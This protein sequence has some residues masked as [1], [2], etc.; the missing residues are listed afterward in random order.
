MIL[1][2]D[3]F[4]RR[5]DFHSGWVQRYMTINNNERDTDMYFRPGV[6]DSDLDS[7]PW[8]SP[9]AREHREQHGGPGEYV[10]GYPD[11][12]RLDKMDLAALVRLQEHLGK[13][14][15][16]QDGVTEDEYEIVTLMDGTRG[17]Q[18]AEG[19]QKLLERE[20]LY[21]KE[22]QILEVYREGHRFSE[23]SSFGLE[24]TEPPG[25][26]HTLRE[27]HGEEGVRRNL[28]LNGMLRM[29]RE[30]DSDEALVGYY[31]LENRKPG[32]SME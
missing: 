29:P 30:S 18:V 13:K 32:R 3:I 15:K 10:P 28:L 8:L 26:E 6:E 2:P 22:V 20:V 17:G 7:T 4:V 12:E 31:S 11:F 9:E 25:T 24:D 1:T 27:G 14:W 21:E 23:L 19:G 16:F 5:E